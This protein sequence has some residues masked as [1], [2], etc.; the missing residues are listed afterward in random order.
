[1]IV[2]SSK[3]S[4]GETL[5]SIRLH[6]VMSQLS[7]VI[8]SPILIMPLRA[9]FLLKTDLPLI[10]INLLFHIIVLDVSS[11]DRSNSFF[12]LAA[13]SAIATRIHGLTSAKFEFCRRISHCIYIS[14]EK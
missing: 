7:S 8:R 3:T 10:Q 11:C 6:E 1:M 2:I 9:S 14:P 4:I 5:R 13:Q 12:F